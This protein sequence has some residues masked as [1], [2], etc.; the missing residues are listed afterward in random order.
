MNAFD[1]TL[2]KNDQGVG[3]W[4]STYIF[5]QA[6]G[7]TQEI[8]GAN[9]LAALNAM[10]NVDTLGLTPPIDYTKPVKVAQ[11]PLPRIFVSTIVQASVKKAKI[12]SAS[13]PPK[14]TDAFG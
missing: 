8:T 3:N 14:F 2:N 12:V 5:E 1:K 9:V 10:T 7:K 13:R 4:L 11:L 6:A